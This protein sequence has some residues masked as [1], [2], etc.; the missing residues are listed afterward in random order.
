MDLFAEG[1]LRHLLDNQL[2]QLRN[3][4]ESQDINYLLNANEMQLVAYLVEKYAIA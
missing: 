4:I 3:E 2:K 1:E